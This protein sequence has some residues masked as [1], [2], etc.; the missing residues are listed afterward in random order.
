MSTDTNQMQ[1][2][3]KWDQAKGRVKEAWGVLTDDDLKRSEGKFD[4]LVGTIK[5]KTGEATDS[6][7]NKLK[8][9]FS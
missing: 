8:E 2:E 5:D 3:G 4:R 7:E 1:M 6:I 9:I